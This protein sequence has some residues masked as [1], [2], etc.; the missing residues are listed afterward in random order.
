MSA[1]LRKPVQGYRPDIDGLRAV[2]VIAVV[3]FHAFPAALAGGFAGVDI[4]FA[5]SGYLI[6]QHIIETLDQQ[7]FSIVGFYARRIKRIYPALITVMAA[8]LAAG[9]VMMASGELEQLAS[10][11]LAS[12]AFVA[13]LYFFTTRDYF[14]Q[15]AGASAL[16]HLWSLGV[17]EQYYIVWPVALFVLWR[18]TSRRVATFAIAAVIALSLASSIVLSGTHAVAAFYLPVTRCW[19]LLFGSALAWAEFH[20]GAYRSVRASTMVLAWTRRVPL[21]ELASCAGVALIALSLAL[22]DPAN[23]FPGWRAALPAGGAT[24]VIAA[25]PTAWLN[26]RVLALRPMTYVGLISYPLYLWHWPIL[27]FLRL[28]SGGA[29]TATMRLA[30]VG[31]AFALSVLTFKCIEAPVRFSRIAR[32][33]PVRMASVLFAMMAGIGV[34]SYAISRDNGLP[35]RFPDASF[36]EHQEHWVYTDACKKAFPGAEFCMMPTTHG[37]AEVALLGDSHANHFYEGLRRELAARGT[38]LLAVGAGNC[39]PFSGVDIYLG[40]YVKH[41]AALFDGVLDYV[42]KSRDIDTVILS[43]YAISSIAGDFDYGKGD[44]I[45]LV[46][47]RDAQAARGVARRGD[48]SN[49]EVYL[50]GLER[51]LTRLRAAGKRVIFVLD[52]PELD[53]DPST[54]VRRPVQ[55]S[56]RSPCAVP[57]S[58]VEQRLSG[59]Q[60]KILVALARFPDVKV[61]N[62]LPLLC[63]KQNCYARQGGEFM[64]TDRDHLTSDGS[65]YIGGWLMRD[66]AVEAWPASR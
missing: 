20:A 51:T 46:A 12:V 10:D 54:C 3:V 55:I 37:R 60:K 21:R 9:I 25:G 26:R 45:R 53:F 5:I 15:G 31:V 13:N 36:N 14:S 32:S 11:A 38:G 28:S 24:L 41:C 64:Y 50:A 59:T 27:V 34:S 61:F 6:T 47:A 48:E 19:E 7:R 63:D 52:T 42:V 43:S 62:P 2:A 30:A 4:F 56:V 65:R 40:T 22:Y 66:I 29:P 39:P 49:M 8:C 35:N 23:V 17:E 1:T 16:L 58:K 18:Y 44:Y 33:H 57:R